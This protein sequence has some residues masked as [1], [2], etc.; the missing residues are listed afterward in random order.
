MGKM[1]IFTPEQ[2]LIFHQ[3][4]KSRFLKSNFY[5]TGGTALSCFYL[6]HRYS[7]D[8][9]F[10]SEKKFNE[11]DLLSEIRLWAK[12]CDFIFSNE[13]RE[14]VYIFTLTFPNQATLKIDFGYYPYKRVL[15]S[16]YIYYLG[17]DRRGES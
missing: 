16:G 15:S 3:V 1:Q 4:G 11:T 10:F 14:V 6:G 12:E 17:P 8:L 2:K 13:F 5:F 7:E 9:D